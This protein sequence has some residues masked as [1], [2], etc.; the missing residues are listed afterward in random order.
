MEALVKKELIL[1]G[2]DCANCAAKIEDKIKKL[3]AVEEVSLNFITK[4]L[5]IDTFGDIDIDIV[6]DAVRTIVYTYEPHVI[7]KEKNEKLESKV[8][9]LKGLTSSRF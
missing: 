6:I 7:V 4:T 2:L 1:E 9:I 8:Y 3:E 5:S